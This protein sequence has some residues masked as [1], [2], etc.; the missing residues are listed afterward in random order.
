MFTLIFLPKWLNWPN[1]KA[2]GK[3]FLTETKGQTLLFGDFVSAAG[4]NGKEGV[5]ALP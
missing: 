2:D 4:K 5:S 3:A 1:N